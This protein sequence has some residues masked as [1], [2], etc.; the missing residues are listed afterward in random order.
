MRI[1]NWH[2]T[3]N[4]LGTLLLSL[5]I[6]VFVM[7]SVHL[8]RAF[9]M[10]SS[11]VSPL[12]L[13]KM[14][15]YLLP[16]VLR[17]ALPFSILVSTVLVFSRM[18]ADNEIVALKASGVGIW[19]IVAPALALALIICAASLWLSADIAPRLR[20]AGE[21]LRWQA[22]TTNPLALL[23]PGTITR[24][25]SQT[26][27]RVGSRDEGPGLLKDIHL[28]QTDSQAGTLRD[29]TAESC[30]IEARPDERELLLTLY[31]F[32]IAERPLSTKSVDAYRDANDRNPRFLAG[33]AL[34]MHL[35]YGTL[36]DRKSL[37]RKLSMMPVKMLL[38]DIVWSESQGEDVT[39]HWYAFHERLALAFSPLAFL[40][41]GIPFGIRN[42][43]SEA[44]SGLLICLVMAL[45]YYGVMLLCNS[46]IH[47]PR[48]H[49]EYIIWLPN[50]AYQIGGLLALRKIAQH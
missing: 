33:D 14:L 28:Y 40:L 32:T 19:Q 30:M 29:I 20:Y 26:S 17:Y 23:E 15:V 21:R 18:S 13:G 41:L 12:L 22:V 25:S 31:N 4:L 36:Q 1:F 34:T 38:G 5:G 39:K 42:R 8:F 45:A 9:A 43:R 11:G 47:H 6:L 16:E 50:I 3:K 24:L 48:L 2:I 7:M 44:A 46:L 35:E 10:L 49:P 27:I 37:T